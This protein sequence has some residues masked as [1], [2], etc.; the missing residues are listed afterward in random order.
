MADCCGSF[1]PVSILIGQIITSHGWGFPLLL[2]KHN[3]E[4]NFFN[5][6][7]VVTWVLH[8]CHTVPFTHSRHYFIHID[9]ILIWYIVINKCILPCNN[10]YRWNKLDFSHSVRICVLVWASW[11]RKHYSVEWDLSSWPRLWLMKAQSDVIGMN[12]KYNRNSKVTWPG[13]TLFG[14]LLL[15]WVNIN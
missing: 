14:W 13:C 5:S 1:R 10:G 7:S 3:T 11:C 12:S 15:S 6:M 2:R 9:Y 8:W 4:G